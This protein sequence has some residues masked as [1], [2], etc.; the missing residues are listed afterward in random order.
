MLETGKGK[1][2][3]EMEILDMKIALGWRKVRLVMICG[4]YLECEA[5]D[6]MLD[7]M[8]H[9]QNYSLAFAKKE[10]GNHQTGA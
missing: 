2:F 6:V 9:D 3:T 10:R 4:R 8:M 5:S 1:Q 7:Q